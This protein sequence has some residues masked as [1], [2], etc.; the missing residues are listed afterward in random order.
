MNKILKNIFLQILI[1]SLLTNIVVFA[2]NNAEPAN[3]EKQTDVSEY[4][5]INVSNN[6][7]INY[8]F[9]YATDTVVLTMAA[10]TSDESA[11]CYI[12]NPNHMIV[13][14]GSVPVI[15][16]VYT[17][18]FRL[19]NPILGKYT[20]KL[21]VQQNQIVDII[22][23][24]EDIRRIVEN[25]SCDINKEFNLIIAAENTSQV[26]K[27]SYIIK[28]DPTKVKLLDS[29][30]LTYDKEMSTGLIPGTNI[31]ILDINTSD[32]TI[33]FEITDSSTGRMSG[34]LNTLKF[35]CLSS[36]T[37]TSIYMEFKE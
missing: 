20:G 14:I 1:L 5:E 28:Y 30:S 26:D 8:S 6:D 37:Q 22:F 10:A 27:T 33:E 35:V 3:T 24:V 11:T 12:E 2:D 23:E 25:I 19:D 16:G 4:E 36:N 21:K 34:I 15:N 18:S 13:Y 17:L 29:C 9:D 32:G 7:I 31:N